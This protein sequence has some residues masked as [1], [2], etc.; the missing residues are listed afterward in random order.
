MPATCIAQ[1]KSETPPAPSHADIERQKNIVYVHDYSRLETRQYFQEQIID[2]IAYFHGMGA[3]DEQDVARHELGE[4]FQV[5][6]L[7]LCLD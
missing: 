1:S 4:K 5:N 7:N 2:V 3:V 6:V